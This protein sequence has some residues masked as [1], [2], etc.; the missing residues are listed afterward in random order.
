[1]ITERDNSKND[2]I[3]FVDLSWHLAVKKFD[4]D[5][6]KHFHFCKTFPVFME[7]MNLAFFDLWGRQITAVITAQKYIIYYIFTCYNSS[8]P[9]FY[10][11]KMSIFIMLT[12]HCWDVKRS[13]SPPFKRASELCNRLLNRSLWFE[14]RPLWP[15]HQPLS[16]RPD[17]R[18]TLPD[19]V[20][21]KLLVLF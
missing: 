15:K 9:R 11:N 14:H 10:V 21:L 4:F 17:G 18:R 2:Y 3:E 12:Q 1:M 6:L 16:T 5:S 20:A 13:S 19:F 7:I 8:L